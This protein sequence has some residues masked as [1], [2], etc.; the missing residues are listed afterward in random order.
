MICFIRTRHRKK[1]E[2]HAGKNSPTNPE[3]PQKISY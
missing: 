3:A 1:E 2:I